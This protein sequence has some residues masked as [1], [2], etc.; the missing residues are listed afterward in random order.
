MKSIIDYSD[1]RLVVITDPHIK[2]DN[3]FKVYSEGLAL[4]GKTDEEGSY[5]SIFIS[6]RTG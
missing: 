1:R 6:E 5:N 3:K 2:V 4:H